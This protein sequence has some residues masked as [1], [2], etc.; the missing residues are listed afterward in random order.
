MFTQSY[1][2]NERKN[3]LVISGR[4]IAYTENRIITT[5]SLGEWKWNK[6]A[7][8]QDLVINIIYI[9]MDQTV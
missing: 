1:E 8:I 3:E 4:A 5:A 2:S 9:K 6:Y 7:E